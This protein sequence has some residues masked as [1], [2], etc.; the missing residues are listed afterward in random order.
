MATQKI[1]L[2]EINTL[3]QDTF[4]HTL[5]GLFEGPPWIITQAWLSRPFTSR[6]QLYQT[7]CSIMYQAPAEQQIALLRAHPDLVGRA[8]LAGTLSPASTNEQA[9]AGLD[10]LTAEEIATFQR[11]NQTYQDQFGFP[12]VICARENKK[13]SI[14][15]GFSARLQHIRQQEID[16]ALGEVAKICALR[17]R[18]L[19]DE[20]HTHQDNG[21][22]F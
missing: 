6:Q 8:A 12:F 19:I 14:L 5:A 20:M 15:D 13:D 10:R 22:N 4:I 11:L 18:D 9:A 16:I 2:Q 7:L 21:I 3:D 17:L 1:T